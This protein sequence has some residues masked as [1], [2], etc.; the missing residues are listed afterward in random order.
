MSNPIDPDTG[1]PVEP[2]PETPKVDEL[3]REDEDVMRV[4]PD[5]AGASAPTGVDPDTG[6]PPEPY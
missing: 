3:D 6:Q 4:D 2:S 5:T 1:Q